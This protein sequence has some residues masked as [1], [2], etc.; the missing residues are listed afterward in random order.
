MIRKIKTSLLKVKSLSKNEK[1]KYISCCCLGYAEVLF[2]MS[3][4]LVGVPRVPFRRP[5]EGDLVAQTH[6]H[7]SE[8]DG[9][10]Q[11]ERLLWAAMQAR[12]NTLIITDHDKT[13]GAFEVFNLA[14]KRGYIKETNARDHFEV[15][16]GQEVTT[17]EGHL[18]IWGADISILCGLSPQETAE[19]A[20]EQGAL[21][22]V[23]H[24]GFMQGEGLPWDIV[25]GLVEK[26]L[27]HGVEL[28][29]G[30]QETL[31]YMSRLISAFPVIGEWAARKISP[32]GE[33][34]IE[35][36]RHYYETDGNAYAVTGGQDG[37]LASSASLT[38]VVTLYPEGMN[39]FDAVRQK[40]TIYSSKYEPEFW[41]PFM[42][43]LQKGLSRK[44]EEDR[45]N[46]R[47]G[48]MCVPIY[49][50]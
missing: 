44:L 41:G 32:N 25:D 43:L 3:E 4:K 17:R 40:K 15:V 1:N 18:L 49:E 14:H 21:V 48:I 7:T 27:V 2:F 6:Y 29:N 5:Q 33:T 22:V 36:L 13:S 46:N 24:P 12:I 8:S 26:K 11:P 47:N 39:F 37:H 10:A 42:H 16:M 50:R 31:T 9:F 35:A 34:N 30:A 19:I 28:R 45:Q 23:P 38:K 20:L